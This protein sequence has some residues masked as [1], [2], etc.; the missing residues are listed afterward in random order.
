MNRPLVARQLADHAGEMIG[1]G[2]PAKAERSQRQ[3]ATST[4]SAA[5]I[6]G[7]GL[8]GRRHKISTRFMPIPSIVESGH[9]MRQPRA[10]HPFH[11]PRQPIGWPGCRCMVKTLS[12]LR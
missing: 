8:H 2:V 7:D 12:K 4:R 3:A 6:A 10:G 1:A 11:S 9:K 5:S